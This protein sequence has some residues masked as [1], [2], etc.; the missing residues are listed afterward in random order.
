M[1]RF[2]LMD[3]TY[4]WRIRV[5]CSADG[6]YTYLPSRISEALSNPARVQELNAHQY[7]L[8]HLPSDPKYPKRINLEFK[9]IVRKSAGNIT[10]L[11]DLTHFG[12]TSANTN[13]NTKDESM[14]QNFM[15]TF[16]PQ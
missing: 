1:D 8:T 16:N 14:I 15:N 13:I 10:G 11:P 5:N 7:I 12:Q 3:T 9:Q 2:I 4:G 6:F